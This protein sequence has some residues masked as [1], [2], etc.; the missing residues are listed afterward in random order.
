MGAAVEIA[1]VH[2]DM[3]RRVAGS[4]PSS[5]LWTAIGP[6]DRVHRHDGDTDNPV[7][8]APATG[9][10]VTRLP[11]TQTA[12]TRSLLLISGKVDPDALDALILLIEVTSATIDHLGAARALRRQSEDVHR[13][14]LALLGLADA[15]AEPLNPLDAVTDIPPVTTDLTDREREI[16]EIVTSGASNAQIADR[17]T[18]SVE[19]VKSHVKHIL[20]KTN[21]ANRSELIAMFG[22]LDS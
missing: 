6:T 13:M 8:A 16:L 17:L 10:I 15:D 1:S 7:T 3:P 20:R 5:R 9:H 19:T 4:C 21:A 22:G 11:I 14:G 12:Q 18:I 2:G